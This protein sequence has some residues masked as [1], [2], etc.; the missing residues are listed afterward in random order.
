[1]NRE[2]TK[3]AII[4]EMGVKMM[5]TRQLEKDLKI[6]G[7]MTVSGGTFNNVSINGSGV[8]NGDVQCT[9]FKINGACDIKGNLKAETGV[10]RGRASIKED[11]FI[12]DFDVNGRSDLKGGLYASSFRVKGACSIKKEVNTESIKIHGKL[13][14]EAGCNTDSF[15]SDGVVYIEE[16]LQAQEV[17][18]SLRNSNSKIRKIFS[19]SV[20]VRKNNVTNGILG[21]LK[22]LFSMAGETGILQVKEI[23]GKNVHVE[24]TVAEKIIGQHV[25]IGEGCKIALVEYVDT[26][27]VSKDAKVGKQVKV[28]A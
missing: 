25:V 4:F 27:E 15:F 23:N 9:S 24:A 28:G 21:W 11:L 12:H 5:E 22:A 16:V 20:V 2:L 19:E 3:L 7:S 26:I 10:I 1:M 6:N 8:I 17:E 13:D 18:M 14:I